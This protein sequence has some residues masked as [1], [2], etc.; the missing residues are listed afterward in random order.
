[1]A[2]EYSNKTAACIIHRCIGAV[3]SLVLDKLSTSVS[4]LT[5]CQLD[6][7]KAFIMGTDTF[8][9][10]PTGHGKSLIIYQ[11][12]LPV[13][14]ELV[15]TYP[16]ELSQ[17]FPSRPMLLVVSPLNALIT[18]QM[19]SCSKVFGLKVARLDEF[20]IREN[21]QSHN[22][23]DILFTGPETL[24]KNYA[25]I[26]CFAELLLAVVV[27][28]THCVITNCLYCSLVRPKLEYASNVWLPNNIKYRSIIE[29]VQ[30]R[31]TKFI[32]SYPKDMS[33]P[34]RLVETN[35][36]PL[37]FRREMS[38]LQLYKAKMGLISM[39]INKYLST[40][41]P[42]YKSRRNYNVNNFHFVLKHKQNYFK[43]SFF[44]RSA[45]LWNNLPIELKSHVSISIFRNGLQRY[46]KAKLPLYCPPGSV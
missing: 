44:V 39:D 22:D 37:E 7:F 38:D 23:I 45:N 8:V 21:S 32:L 19:E 14:K 9:S 31:A 2:G 40:Y 41:E 16:E 36:L 46:Y 12:A 6:A 26:S 3:L 10:L 30:W 28:E 25:F 15:K 20:I 13:V 35:L 17:C 34:E 29:N 33:Y 24:E 5:P 1:M 18:N 11:I 4:S 43:N 42:G 27:D